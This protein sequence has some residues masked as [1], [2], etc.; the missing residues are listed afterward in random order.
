MDIGHYKE[1]LLAK[2]KELSAEMQAEGTNARGI[3]A[4]SAHETADQSVDDDIKSTLFT[5]ANSQWKELEQVRAALRRIDNGTFGRCAVDGGPIEEKRLKAIPWT[6]YCLKHERR[7]E[8]T[9]P[10]PTPTL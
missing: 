5:E 4:D 3:D 10:T 1:L 8:S 2:E 7:I 6:P 9:D